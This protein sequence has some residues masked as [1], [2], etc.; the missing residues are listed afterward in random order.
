MKNTNRLD[1]LIASLAY[2]GAERQLA[3]VAVGLRE[4]GWNVRVISMMEPQGYAAQLATENVEV[5]TLGMR[6]GKP[7][8]RALFRL[9][10]LFKSRPIVLTNF[11]YHAD[12][13]G[14]VAG[15]IANVP[16]IVSCIRNEQFG[17]QWRDIILRLTRPLVDINV[18]NSR[19]AALACARR[20]VIYPNEFRIIPNG[21]DLS[22]FRQRADSARTAIR[23]QLSIGAADF[24]WVAIGRLEASKD[25]GNLI[26]AFAE[27]VSDRENVKLLIAGEG[28]LRPQL[29][30]RIR[31]R[32]L[33]Q[34]VRCL[35]LRDDVPDLLF[36]ADAVVL[37]SAWEGSPNAILEAMG[38][39]RPAVATNVGGIAELLTDGVNGFVV[40]PRDTIALR[41]GMIR[42]MRLPPAQRV[43]MG[44][45]GRER[46]IERH[47]LPRI[48]EM[49]DG[50]YRELAEVGPPEI[51]V[52]R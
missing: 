46:A 13:L 23:E 12:V 47:A 19:L 2:G 10:G 28:R 36:A 29:A 25:Y 22:R 52:G 5:V 44:R 3:Q 35:G 15:R 30:G 50:L 33:C 20:S 9:L 37:S 39:G 49:W 27:V 21:L 43:K 40:E 34:R 31:E 45:A 38:A 7:D 41:R 8:L 42:M 51:G 6:R 18:V 48:I 16:H 17:G 32:G 1:F 11:M 24:L 4:R 26:D 14:R